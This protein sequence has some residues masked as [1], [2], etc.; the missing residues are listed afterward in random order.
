MRP[1]CSVRR[2]VLVGGAADVGHARVEGGP[3]HL[4]LGAPVRGH[5]D[6][7]IALLTIASQMVALGAEAEAIRAWSASRSSVP[8]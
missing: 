3:E 1:A 7:R 5:H 6:R 8:G 4:F 2:A